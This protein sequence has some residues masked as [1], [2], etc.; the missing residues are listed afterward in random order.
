MVLFVMLVGNCALFAKCMFII[1]VVITGNATIDIA[2]ISRRCSRSCSC[3][4]I[5]HRR[6]VVS[7][8]V[9]VVDNV[10]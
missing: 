1:Y 9:V 4:G 8:V 10:L 3:S 6:C 5:I 7:V 2:T